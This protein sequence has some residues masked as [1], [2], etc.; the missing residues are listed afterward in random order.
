MKDDV[1]KLVE[2]NCAT[3]AGEGKCY[4]DRQ[5]PYFSG[6]EG[7]P[8][9]S[10]FENCVL[11]GDEKLLAQYW[12]SFGS[13]DSSDSSCER[14]D[15]WFHKTSNRQVYCE[16][17]SQIVALDKK[18]ARDRKYREKKRQQNDGLGA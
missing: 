18:R 13:V 7:L 12:N 4:L 3:Y 17:C 5:C 15:K 6:N 9:C 10:Y 16:S 2:N 14:C 8:R 1:K 11:P